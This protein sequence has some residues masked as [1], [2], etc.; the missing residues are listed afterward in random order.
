MAVVRRA[1]IALLLLTG[2]VAGTVADRPAP[3]R[4]V[5]SGDYLV[6]SAD[7]HLHSGMWSGG[8]LTPWGLVL[9]SERQG[10]DVIALTGHNETLD[11]RVARVFS[12]L[13]DGP[14]VLIGQEITSATQDM[15]AVGITS[16]ISPRLPL[17]AQIAEVHRQGGLAIAAH[18]LASYHAAYRPV[19]GAIDGTEVCHPVVWELPDAA[20]QLALFKAATSAMPIGSS[21]FHFS[22]HPGSCR[23]YVFAR[24]A[25]A[26]SVMEAL[27]AR[28]TVVFTPDGRAYGDAAL[29]RQAESLGLREDA[30][31]YTRDRGGLLD[32]VSRLATAAGLVGIA[33]RFRSPASRR[34]AGARESD[35]RAPAQ[36][37]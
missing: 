7:F 13:A 17:A 34:G 25:T 35:R 4:V 28:R 22:G 18:P 11:A 27:R 20:R 31:S 6:L 24:E 2:L 14:V 30:L 8:A 19:M 36:S 5:L 10:L 23:T 32:W 9:E 33:M 1:W 21:D 15:V 12:R 3:R 16:T 37:R 29:V 26:P